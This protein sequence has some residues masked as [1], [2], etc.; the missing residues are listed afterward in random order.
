MKIRIPS[1]FRRAFTLIEIMVVVALM[2]IICGIAVPNLYQMAKKEGLRRAVYD[3]GQVCRNARDQAIM[4]G[5]EVSVVFYPLERR[6]GISGAATPTLESMP[7]TGTTGII[8]D[9]VTLELLEVN[10][11]NAFASNSEWT[12]NWV[13]VRFYPNGTSDEM[14]IVFRSERGELRKLTL[15]PTTGLLIQGKMQ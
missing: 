1:Q 8:P 15:E 11:Q 13:Q 3:L 2:G 5:Q 10:M 14:M 12:Y 7:G 6:F 9:E 4:T